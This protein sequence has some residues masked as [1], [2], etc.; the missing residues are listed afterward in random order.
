MLSAL[1]CVT[2]E[3]CTDTY[4]TYYRQRAGEDCDFQIPGGSIFRTT[5]KILNQPDLKICQIRVCDDGHA[6]EG[7]YCGVGPCNPLGYQCEGGCVTGPPESPH[8]ATKNFI[9]N[10]KNYAFH[11]IEVSK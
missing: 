4:V 2:S 5:H 11:Y 10:Y 9:A 8:D 7:T 3:R 1:V 6:H